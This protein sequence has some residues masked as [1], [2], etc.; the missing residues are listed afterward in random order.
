[1]SLLTA[2]DNLLI[3]TNQHKSI[4]KYKIHKTVCNYEILEI[5]R[6]KIVQKYLITKKIIRY[7]NHII[8]LMVHI[9]NFFFKFICI[10]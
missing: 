2:T 7:C 10:L 6:I 1:M 3:N 5:H 8:Q 4:Y 9:I